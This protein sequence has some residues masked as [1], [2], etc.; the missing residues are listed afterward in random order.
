M[1]V[2]MSQFNVEHQLLEEQFNDLVF[3]CDYG[4][5][6]PFIYRG[7]KQDI[8]RNYVTSITAPEQKRE[9]GAGK[10]VAAVLETAMIARWGNKGLKYSEADSSIT[11]EGDFDFVFDNTD[12][13]VHITGGWK[14]RAVWK[15]KVES[16][17]TFPALIIFKRHSNCICC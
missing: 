11:K 16:S 12:Y 7:L 2:I 15:V 17:C 14:V 8:F 3:A 4:K 1:M 10:K 6:R 5:P 9:W 13:R